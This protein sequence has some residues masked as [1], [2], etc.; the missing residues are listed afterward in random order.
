MCQNN[1]HTEKV[2]VWGYTDEEIN[3][4]WVIHSKF[5]PV[6]RL[7]G[8]DDKEDSPTRV[9]APKVNPDKMMANLEHLLG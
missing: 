5:D 9:E 8:S 2:T 1:P 4:R 7:F 6:N 3:H